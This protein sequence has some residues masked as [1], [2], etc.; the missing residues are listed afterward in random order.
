MAMARLRW[1][2]AALIL[3]AA[4]MAHAQLAIGPAIDI[5]IAAYPD[6]LAGQDGND[7]IWKDGTRMPI[8]DGRATKSFEQLLQTA[9]IAN[10]FAIPYPLGTKLKPPAVN[11]D[12]GRI[13]NHAFFVKM[14]GDCHKGEVANRLKSVP[15]LP[16]RGGGTI[17]ATTVNGVADRLAAVS[18]DLEKLPATMTRFMVPSA[19]VYNCRNVADTKQLSAHAYGAAID[20]NTN[21]SD[22]WLWTRPQSNTVPWRNHIPLEIV[23]VFERHG[24]IWGGKWYH[25][26]TMHFEYRPELIAL[27]KKGWPAR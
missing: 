12:P 11:E 9:D 10:Q 23:D 8:S 6:H 25:Y 15:W 22:Y 20:L 13:R 24:F 17:K 14:Y 7:L 3:A 5:L 1:P 16:K 18:D 4:V 19:G 26:D 27:A 21:Y 2:A